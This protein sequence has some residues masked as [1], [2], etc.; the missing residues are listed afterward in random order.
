MTKLFFLLLISLLTASTNFAQDCGC[1]DKP[2]PDVLSVV[3]GVKIT[4]KDL[5]AATNAR[6][7]EL[8][9]QVIDARARELDLQINS[10]LLETEAKRLKVTTKKLL[11]DEV[12]TKVQEPT[13]AEARK[14][15]DE[16]K[17]NIESSVGGPVQFEQVKDRI[18][19]HL[20]EE[21]QQEIA[22]KLADRLRA[23]AD[24]KVL[25][26]NVTPPAT[27]ADRQRLLATVN[28]QKIT[29]ADIEDS[30]RP[31]VFNVQEEMYKTRRGDLNLK[32][33]DLLL[34]QEAQKRQLT[35]RALLD[36]E[37]NSKVS[38]ITEADAQKFFNENKDRVNGTFAELKDQIIRYLQDT[39]RNNRQLAFAE[40]LRKG[41]AVQEFLTP[42]EPPVFT[43]AVDDQPAVG[44][45]KAPVTI[46]EF[47]DFQCPTCARMHPVL[48]RLVKEYP[49]RVR[50]VV[51]DYPLQQHENAFKAAEAAEAAREQ[52]KYWE[53]TAK[54]FANQSALG[55]DQL[56]QYA[57]QVGLDRAKFDAA[58]DSGKF[59]AQVERDI[60]DGNK[61]NVRGTPSF[62]VNGRPV[63]DLTYEGLK[64]AIDAVK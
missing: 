50:L 11:E 53:Y 20:R 64:R 39:E 51:R 33:N 17:A 21:R 18:V 36:A 45:V 31:L 6:I 37:V 19:A 2:L 7:T 26:P 34:T 44:D 5:D 61:L 25:V 57:T 60:L 1:E 58:L 13:E 49:G 30:L 9:Q 46:V 24:V 48:D 8:K 59:K 10:I 4:A 40:S 42:P 62:F 41:A 63:S 32:I 54:L 38:P 43:I 55:V 35:T 12:V 22:K 52:G 56:K 47:T 27:P 28:G 23:A 29:S 3:N 16:K 15:F 14:F